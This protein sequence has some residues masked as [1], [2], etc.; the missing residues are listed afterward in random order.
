M[1][2]YLLPAI[3]IYC[4]ATRLLAQSDND[5]INKIKNEGLSNSKVMDIAFHLTDASGR[6]KELPKPRGNNGGR[7]F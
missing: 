3:F 4:C 1:K 2:K 7:T 6:G 5:L